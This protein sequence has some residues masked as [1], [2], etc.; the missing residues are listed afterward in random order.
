MARKTYKKKTKNGT[1]YYFF[2][3]FYKDNRPKDIYA[4]SVSEMEEKIG[5]LL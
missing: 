2:R 4:N 1:E 5:C 3:L